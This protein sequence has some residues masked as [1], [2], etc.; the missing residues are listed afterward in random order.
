MERRKLIG[1]LLRTSAKSAALRGGAQLHA[2]LTK[3]G[4][5]FDT[6]LG[7]NLVDMYAKCGKLAMAG[8][9]FDGMP[10]RNVV[11]WTALM[12]GF[13]QHG[14]ARECLSLLGEMRASSEAAPNEYTLSASLKTC[15]VAGDTGA[16][17][18]IH[19]LCVRTGYE[20]HHVVAN[21]LVLMYSKGGRIGDARRVFDGI[22]FRNLVTWNAMISGYAHAGRGRDALAMFRE[23]QQLVEGEQ[24]ADE[25]TFAS[26]LKAC[27][28][29]GAPRQGAQVHAAMTA[30]GLLLSNAILAGALVDL[31]AKCRCLPAAMR[32]LESLET[33]NAVQWTAVVVGH[34]QEG[35]VTEAMELFRR[36]WRSGVGADAHVL[37]SVVGVFADFALIEQGRQVHGYVVKKPQPA[38]DV[39]VG[40]SM[41]DMYL[42]CGLVDEAHQLFEEM[43]ARNVV[44]WTAMINGLGKHGLGREAIAMFERM[45]ADGVEP[46][47]VAYLALLSACSHAGLV[48]ECRH[49]F[50][51]IVRPRAE[52]YACMVDLLGRAGELQEARDLILRRM[53]MEPTVGIWQTLLSAC[54]VH[55]DVA[56]AWEAGGVLL[57][58][59]G[60][61]PAN[62][63]MLSNVLA[64]AGE[65]RAC[66]E[67]RDAMRRRGLKKQGGCSW[68]EVGKEVHFFYGGG[69][70]AHPRAA[71][72]RRVLS[73]VETTMREQLG[74]SADAR[75]ALHD[76]D[77]ESRADSLGE[78]S[79][80]LAV[81]LCLLLMRSDSAGQVIRVYKNLRVC[82]DCH[83]FFKGLSA[84]LDVVLVIRDAN[85]FH[86][87]QQGACSCRDYW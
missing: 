87:F 30:R 45:R 84:V 25:F 83:H 13:L 70:H 77:D 67:V 59:D 27:S 10:E 14:K 49:F 21:S 79:E 69:D 66:H 28:G 72:I 68:V 2:S 18:R 65:W 43:P 23:M 34:A 53:P 12:V 57:A 50:S 31:Y 75:S 11:S 82:D 60:D 6:M 58:V 42:K 44:S 76:V 38:E 5:V 61:N 39:S 4:F 78:H 80:R 17:V 74:Y 63:V 32:V 73:R 24:L 15:C 55:G 51:R 8:E 40:N 56:V 64:E 9:V 62:Y 85:R 54:R 16:G 19:G 20:E 52:H 47:E 36:F 41:V 48:E 22:R 37:S 33:K 29:L 81:G 3:L 26:L 46:D 7:N 71:D 35:R 1:D 86:R